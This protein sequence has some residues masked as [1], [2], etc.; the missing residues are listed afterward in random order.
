MLRLIWS[1][2]GRRSSLEQFVKY[3]I[4]YILNEIL[5]RYIYNIISVI[6]QISINILY[7]IYY[8]I[9]INFRFEML[10]DLHFSQSNWHEARVPLLVL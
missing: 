2:K 8:I 3:N 1:R 6:T 4:R 9:N 5:L 10:F 7:I